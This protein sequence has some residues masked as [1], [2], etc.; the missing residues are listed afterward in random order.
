MNYQS[1]IYELRNSSLMKEKKNVR[2]G[3]RDRIWVQFNIYIISSH[4]S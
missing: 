3:I 1:I 2:D 4:L